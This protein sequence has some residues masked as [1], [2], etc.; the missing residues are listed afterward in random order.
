MGVPWTQENVPWEG[1]YRG[2][3]GTPS[4]ES[5][6]EPIMWDSP[7][8]EDE[9]HV[10]SLRG[11]WVRVGGGSS[12]EETVPGDLEIEQA[13][14][15]PRQMELVNAQTPEP[16]PIRS[17]E[18]R[19]EIESEY[20]NW[21][22]GSR[23]LPLRSP[24]RRMEVE[25][26]YANW[27]L[28]NQ[29]LEDRR[30]PGTPA[31]PAPREHPMLTRSRTMTTPE[32]HV[33]YPIT[34]A[35]RRRTHVP[36]LETPE[37]RLPRPP[38]VIRELKEQPFLSPPSVARLRQ[39]IP[40]R[41]PEEVGPTAPPQGTRDEGQ[42]KVPPEG[43]YPYSAE[44][45]Q[46]FRQALRQ[47]RQRTN[48]QKRTAEEE[49][50][51][52]RIPTRPAIT[53][54][55]GSPSRQRLP[56]SPE[57]EEV[58]ASPHLQVRLRRLAIPPEVV[59]EADSR[60]Q[61]QLV[62][63][64]LPTPP[65]ARARHDPRLQPR[66][67]LERLRIPVDVVAEADPRLQPKVRLSK[68]SWDPVFP[69]ETPKV[70]FAT[71]PLSRRGKKD[72]KK[73][74]QPVSRLPRLSIPA[75][76]VRTAISKALKKSGPT[77]PPVETRRDPTPEVKTATKVKASA[78]RISREVKEF[79]KTKTA[80]TPPLSPLA[81]TTRP[82]D[83]A[84][85]RLKDSKKEIPWQDRSPPRRNPYA[86]LIPPTERAAL[87]PLRR[88]EDEEMP[89]PRRTPTPEEE[90]LSDGEALEVAQYLGE[91]QPIP[92][93]E[94]RSLPMRRGL[95]HSSTSEEDEERN[96]AHGYEKVLKQKRKD[97]VTRNDPHHSREDKK[98]GGG[99]GGK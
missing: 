48:A 35:E 82:R 59:A 94:G 3:R 29:G 86:A 81:A 42:E 40:L 80:S 11:R 27:S 79:F 87:R 61:P 62:I 9:E 91:P 65:E 60:L 30:S 89:P 51:D 58:T 76:A 45:R 98:K 2:A 93:N 83:L 33:D 25:H 20:V 39:P 55:A 50:P 72:Q 19:M 34:L 88:E 1:A 95:P 49:I 74:A 70:T 41:G 78:K 28:G 67:E 97:D 96:R 6:P 73:A 43:P 77:P 14:S 57:E 68:S 46:L 15:P 44:Q 26:E 4:S 12:S 23:F 54:P 71:R 7:R 52:R 17:P 69:K 38:G 64:R 92:S 24:E 90:M 84:Q 22:P 75:E 8:P 47:L 63:R 13:H 56:S 16:L 31:L 32:P 10:V 53:T 21:N 66:V 36:A 99:R 37:V 18:R 5:S 85:Q